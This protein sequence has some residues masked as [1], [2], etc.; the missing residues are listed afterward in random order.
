MSPLKRDTRLME[1]KV[2]TTI[3]CIGV[4]KRIMEK[5]MDTTNYLGFRVD[6]LE[7]GIWGLC[8]GL[9]GYCTKII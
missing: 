8:F 4:L 6:G 2:E 5:K 7:F 9:G 3:S 1:K